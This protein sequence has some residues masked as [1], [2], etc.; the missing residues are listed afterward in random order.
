MERKFRLHGK[1]FFLTYPRTDVSAEDLGQHIVSLFT[2][3]D[4]GGIVVVKESHAGLDGIGAENAESTSDLEVCGFHMH[5]VIRLTRK[6]SCS[7]PRFFDYLGHHPNCQP[8]RCLTAALKYISKEMVDY[9]EH[10]TFDKGDDLWV[11]FQHLESELAV[12]EMC[13]TLGCVH[14][15]NYYVRRWKLYKMT[16]TES[17]PVR[18]LDEFVV[19][20]MVSEWIENHNNKSLVLLGPSGFGKTSMARAVAHSLGSFLWAPERQALCAYSGE[21]CVVFDDL[22]LHSAARTTVLNFVDVEQSRAFRVLYG[23]VTVSAGVRRIF[24]SNRLEDLF[25]DKAFLPEVDRRITIV[26]CGDL[27]RGEHVLRRSEELAPSGRLA[28]FLPG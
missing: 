28:G 21:S 7:T 25:G 9:W 12:M 4:M 27:R 11:H 13:A 8:T 3:T 1:H 10:G 19:P 26:H 18:N 15:C 22:D 20:V 16:L 24:S 17:A 6:W 2:D 5:C 23:S 14:H